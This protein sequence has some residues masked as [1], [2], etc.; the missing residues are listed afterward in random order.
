M[1]TR[2]YRGRIIDVD[3]RRHTVKVLTD[4]DGRLYENV[5]IRSPLWHYE[6]YGVGGL[7]EVNAICHIELSSDDTPP[8]VVG[9]SELPTMQT[10]D[11]MERDA[12]NPDVQQPDDEAQMSFAGAKPLAMPGDF[13]VIGRDGNYLFIRRGGIIQIGSS[14]FCQRMYLP[15]RNT[16]R[17][18][19][20]NYALST[21]GG[22]L[23]LES[24][25]EED[26]DD[27]SAGYR[28]RV[29]ANENLEDDKASILFSMG[30]LGNDQLVRLLV[31]PAGIERDTGDATS[32]LID[33]IMKKDGSVDLT[34]TNWTQTVNGDL[35][36]S[37]TGTTTRKAMRYVIQANDGEET[38]V[39]SKRITASSIQL[40][41]NVSLGSSGRFIAG[42]ALEL[43]AYLA[44]HRHD[45]VTGQP[46]GLIPD[47]VVRNFSY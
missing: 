40:S 36:E 23:L 37:V 12:G 42:N 26:S 34:T 14:A 29:F 38:Y 39:G 17:D 28:M 47:V 27:A 24:L 21:V 32:S 22:D 1:T 15:I 16:V 9:F 5:Q 35:A 20:E 13:F 46:V 33:L 2:V 4:Q 41:G 30:K 44:S 6:G 18:F 43:Q 31:S 10:Q 19:A 7:P 45:P 8:M 3:S 25:R 11:E